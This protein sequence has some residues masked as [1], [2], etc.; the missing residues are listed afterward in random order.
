MRG[1]FQGAQTWLR[2]VGALSLLAVG[3]G[4]CVLEFVLGPGEA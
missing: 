3:R 4:G 2:T 1:I